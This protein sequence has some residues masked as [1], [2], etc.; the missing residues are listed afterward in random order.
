[1]AGKAGNPELTPLTQL[2]DFSN[3][4]E[5]N[6][7][8]AGAGAQVTNSPTFN[9]KSALIRLLGNLCWKNRENQDEVSVVRFIPI[10]TTETASK[11]KSIG[12]E[13]VEILKNISCGVLV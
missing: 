1:M 11:I 12:A 5:P 9:F 4:M 6:A 10:P 2:S 7:G 13:W 8:S 3:Q